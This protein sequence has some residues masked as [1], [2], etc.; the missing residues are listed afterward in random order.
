MIYGKTDA[1]LKELTLLFKERTKIEKRYLALLVGNLP[2]EEG[3]INKPL[4][5]DAFSGRVS[6]CPVEKGGKNAL[7]RYKVKKR[8][9]GYTLVEVDLVT[10]RT[11]QIRVHFASIGYPLV[12]DEKYGDFASCREVKAKTGLDSQFLHAYSLSFG[13]LDG[14]LAKLSN[15]SFKA[16]M[17]EFLKRAIEAL[18]S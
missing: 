1:A 5:K 18:V 14:T 15:Q 10:G 17:P 3:E 7:T 4:Y 11:H 12:G 9:K 13:K 16:E 2:N 8:Y 6:V